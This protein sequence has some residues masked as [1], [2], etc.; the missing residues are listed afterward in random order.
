MN[1]HHWEENLNYLINLSSRKKETLSLV[2]IDLDNFKQVNDR[3]GHAEGDALLKFVAKSMKKVARESDLLVRLGGDEFA[4]AMPNTNCDRANKFI[5][6][7]EN[8]V[9]QNLFS[10]GVVATSKGEPFERL[11]QRADRA[12]YEIKAERRS[13]RLA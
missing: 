8:E 4:V 6:R 9:G 5:N 10:A 1:R 3:L 11:L 2:Y 13:L 12:M 7:L